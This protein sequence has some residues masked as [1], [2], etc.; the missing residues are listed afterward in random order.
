MIKKGADMKEE[1]SRTDLGVIKIHRKVIV[2]IASAAALEVEGVKR[3]GADMRSKFFLLF[4]PNAQN[5]IKVNMDKNGEV[6]LEIPVIVKYNLNL[7]EIA[8]KV[9]ENVRRALDKMTNLVVRDIN[10]SIQG[11][12][13]E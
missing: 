11:I 6:K 9:Q 3:I 5:A 4:D 2:S 10:V 8:G 12:E 7:T 13:R 1:E